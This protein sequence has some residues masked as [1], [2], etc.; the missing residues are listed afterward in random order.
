M[1]EFTPESPW[2]SYCE[3]ENCVTGEWPFSARRA[4]TKHG[5]YICD[6]C[7]R[8]G[9]KGKCREDVFDSWHDPN[10]DIVWEP[11]KIVSNK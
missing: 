2:C 4:L 11:G 9:V 10:E 3:C 5:N 6:V 8:Y 7:Y 1:S